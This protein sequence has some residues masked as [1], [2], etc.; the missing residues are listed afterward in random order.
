MAIAEARDI[1]IISI[2]AKHDWR[3]AA[4]I[5]EHRFTDNWGLP[6]KCRRGLHDKLEPV[7]NDM[8]YIDK[9]TI[10]EAMEIVSNE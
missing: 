6:P 9:A 10:R 8:E 1:V 4:W 7:F 2:A 5:L 3:A